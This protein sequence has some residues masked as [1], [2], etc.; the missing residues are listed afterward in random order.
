MKHDETDRLA[1]GARTGLPDALCVLLAEYPR[2]LWEEDVGFSPLIRFWLDRHVMFRRIMAALQE[3]TQAA[4]GTSLEPQAYARKL[5]RYG[6]MFVSE[7]HMHHVIEDTQYFPLMKTL[8][9]RITHGFDIL[10]R[11]HHTIDARLQRFAKMA[12]EILQG[13]QN[14]QSEAMAQLGPLIDELSALDGFL[15]RHLIDEEE[16]IVPVLLKYQPEGLG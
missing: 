4:L 13:M 9:A 15:D 11:D 3:D 2:D 10:D 1:L 5:S 16:L 14:A 12:N 6:G 7:L 8:D